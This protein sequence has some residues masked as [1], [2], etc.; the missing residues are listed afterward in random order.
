M[1]D[2]RDEKATPR[3]TLSP[4][5]LE[6]LRLAADG[7]T[8]LEIGIILGISHRTVDDYFVDAYRRLGVRGR[9]QAVAR[10]KELG[11]I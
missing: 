3:N 8:S 1:Q 6:C 4:R 5:Q 9:V 11:F 10:A 7:K 2:D